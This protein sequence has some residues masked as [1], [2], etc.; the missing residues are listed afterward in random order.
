MIMYVSDT[1]PGAT[2]VKD[3]CLVGYDPV[4]ERPEYSVKIPRSNAH[5]LTKVVRFESDDPEGYDSYKLEYLQVV[6]LLDL[7]G[8]DTNPPKH[9][10]YFI[11]PLVPE[12]HKGPKGGH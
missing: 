2:K 5:L 8:Q 9:F 6:K 1:E 12:E 7:L 4:S 11:E 10:E 3:H